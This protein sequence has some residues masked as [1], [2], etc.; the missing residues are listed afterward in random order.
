[1]FFAPI[2]S[3][4]KFCHPPRSEGLMA[5]QSELLKIQPDIVVNVHNITYTELTGKGGVDIHDSTKLSRLLLS[6]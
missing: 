2:D 1:M 4:L 6:C 3:A 5:H